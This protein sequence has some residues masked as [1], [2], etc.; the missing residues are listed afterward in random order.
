MEQV[1]LHRGMRAPKALQDAWTE[2]SRPFCVKQIHILNAQTLTQQIQV[3]DVFPGTHTT[4]IAE[5][6]QCFLQ[7][8]LSVC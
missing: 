6:G 1:V 2:P 8:G 7:P 3:S 4:H 5:S